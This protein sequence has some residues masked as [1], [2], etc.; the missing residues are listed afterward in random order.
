M[1]RK[2]ARWSIYLSSLTVS[3]KNVARHQRAYGISLLPFSMA[4]LESAIRLLLRPSDSIVCF[5]ECFSAYADGQDTSHSSNNDSTNS[6]HKRIV[7]VVTH[8]DEINGWEEGSVFVLKP[9]LFSAATI[10]ELEIHRVFPI[11]GDFTMTMAQMRQ[12]TLDLSRLSVNEF[13]SGFKVTIHPGHTLI[14]SEPLDLATYDI[15]GLKN[16]LAE[17]R[18]LKELSG[19]FPSTV[20][21]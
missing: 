1:R 5:V 3:K 7:V 9:K 11:Y 10:K 18:R 19:S 14:G 12:E 2:R 4:G 13:R 16:V 20:P 8:R 21:Y 6:R 17:C 15:T